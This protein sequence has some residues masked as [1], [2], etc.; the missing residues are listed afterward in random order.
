MTSAEIA[1]ITVTALLFGAAVAMTVLLLAVKRVRAHKGAALFAIQF[2]FVAAIA[3]LSLAVAEYYDLNGVK[4][5]GAVLIGIAGALG[6]LGVLILVDII[7]IRH[8]VPWLTGAVVLI[9]LLLQ[10]SVNVACPYDFGDSNE[11][12]TVGALIARVVSGTFQYF[13]LDAG[14]TEI[15]Q[16]GAKLPSGCVYVFYVLACSMTVIAPIM[17][18]FAIFGVLGHFFPKLVLWRSIKPTK[19]VF[20][21]LNEYSIETAESIAELK[22]KLASD[23]TARENYLL[24]YGKQGY[25]EIMRSVI[26][27]TDV[28][29]DKASEVDSELLQRA[30]DINAICLKDDVLTRKIYWICGALYRA[31][32]HTQKKVVYFLMDR[33]DFQSDKGVES[34]LQTAVSLLSTEKSK[35]MWAKTHWWQFGMKTTDVEIYVFSQSANADGIIREAHGE[36]VKN[37]VLGLDK[38]RR[39]E[40]EIA[41]ERICAGKKLSSADCPL[42]EQQKK[43][44]RAYRIARYEKYLVKAQ[45]VLSDA[46]KKH[47]IVVSDGVDNTN[48]S[49]RAHVVAYNTAETVSFRAIR[50]DLEN[51]VAD[52]AD[53]YSAIN[54]IDKILKIANA[55]FSVLPS[56]VTYKTINEYQNLVYNLIN[57]YADDDPTKTS[58]PLFRG[59]ARTDDGK[60]DTKKLNILVLGGGRIAKAFIKSAYWCGQMLNGDGATKLR[61]AVMSMD[62]PQSESMLRFEMPDAFD[63]TN[64]DY[65]VNPD[66]YCEFDFVPAQ[67]G[68]DKFVEKF[69][70]LATGRAWAKDQTNFKHERGTIDIDY[71]LVALGA[72]NVNMQAADWIRR[73]LGKFGSGSG[74]VIP[75]N[76]VIEND[77]LCS[78]LAHDEQS[79]NCVLNPF[80]SLKDRFAFDNV[81]ITDLERR[82]L[83]ADSTHGGGSGKQSFLL[84]N[85]SRNSSIAAA[86]HTPYKRTCIDFSADDYARHSYWLEHRRWNA[87][88]RSTGFKCYTAHEFATLAVKTDKNGNKFIS[89]KNKDLKL[90]VCLLETTD[91]LT[92]TSQIYDFLAAHPDFF[93]R[94]FGTLEKIA[95]GEAVTFK[96]DGKKREIVTLADLCEYIRVTFNT[97]LDDLDIASAMV[98]SVRAGENGALIIKPT[99]YKEYDIAITKQLQ[100]EY[101]GNTINGVLDGAVTAALAHARTALGLFA[102]EFDDDANRRCDNNDNVVC[103]KR[104]LFA[105]LSQCNDYDI[106][107]LRTPVS[108]V[109]NWENSEYSDIVFDARSFDITKPMPNGFIVKD[110]KIEDGGKVCVLIGVPRGKTLSLIDGS[111]NVLTVGVSDYQ[112]YQK[113]L[114]V[115]NPYVGTKTA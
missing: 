30:S 53:L 78:A 67:Y 49:P 35:M 52:C 70:D 60:Y 2:L 111:N 83:I 48:D 112:N 27:F 59:L 57:A 29:A 82:A 68:T 58:Y 18:G 12:L 11:R 87:Y 62:A 21:E 88:M 20:S 8:K 9:V 63:P 103:R 90:H 61:M 14:Y 94:L 55:N 54:A 86:L 40:E 25:A 96:S 44:L 81:C 16:I 97:A 64:S 98:S 41:L 92:P 80:G 73:E 15:I 77:A 65:S 46:R 75:I 43:T 17:G 108:T 47:I 31:V 26:I 10:I 106:L 109:K 72:D 32:T 104:N 36:W 3:M 7:P 28:Y 19:Y 93:E 6:V 95:D 79:E 102:A 71:V 114:N 51:A 22:K 84:D 4:V 107:A 105:L 37:Y 69:N 24:K 34:N 1:L 66:S 74:K 50:T 89:P 110:G 56:G 101:L 76:Y 5:C 99:N 38:K 33:A 13:S 39:T 45:K 100:Q 91:A 23:K 113:I 42:D 115:S 85:Y